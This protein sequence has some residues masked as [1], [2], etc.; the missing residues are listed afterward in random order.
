MI[1]EGSVQTHHE[2]GRSGRNSR[3]V[4][5]DILGAL[6]GQADGNDRPEAESLADQR[7]H[8]GH[9][10]LHQTFLPRISIGVDLHDF[11]VSLLLDPLAVLGCQISDA[12]DQVSRDSVQ[13]GRDHGDADGFDLGW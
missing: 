1:G 8:V 12:H 4:V 9:L 3:A 11:I 13:S 2:E 5:L 7:A 6:T 10:L